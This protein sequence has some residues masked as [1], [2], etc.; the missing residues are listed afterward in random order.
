MGEHEIP[1]N[2]SLTKANTH[3]EHS[4]FEQP[5]NT[6]YSL[7][8]S[9]EHD[10]VLTDPAYRMQRKA[11]SD[12]KARV[13]LMAMEDYE[14]D[15]LMNSVWREPLGKQDYENL[16]N[17]EVIL[18]KLDR[19]FRKLTKFHSRAYVDPVNHQRRE[20]R[21]LEKANKRWDNS[22]TIFSDDL[23]EEEQ[24]YRDY[25]ET[26]IQSYREDERV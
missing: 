10:R 11:E 2:A 24:R 12:L 16:I 22:Y 17:A 18:K 1:N 4:H 7:I 3:Y 19:K 13:Y 15:K 14:K 21:M 26:D 5:E 20:R 8:S 25:F 23:T 9:D 6:I